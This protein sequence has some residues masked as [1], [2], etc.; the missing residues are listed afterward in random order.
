[1]KSAVSQLPDGM[2]WLGV[3]STSRPLLKNRKGEQEARRIVRERIR[4]KEN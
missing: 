1:M 2:T 4:D 3:I